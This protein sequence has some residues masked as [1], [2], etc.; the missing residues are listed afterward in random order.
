MK[1]SQ[2]LII[3]LREFGLNPH[4]W[5]LRKLKQKHRWMVIHKKEDLCLLGKT[6]EKKGWKNLEWLI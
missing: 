5:V 3:Q 6:E 1:D 2:N 4:Y